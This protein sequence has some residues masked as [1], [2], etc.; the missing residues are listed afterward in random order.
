MQ[1]GE[2]RFV[3]S[4]IIKQKRIGVGYRIG[5]LIVESK[6]DEQRA[7]YTVWL[8]RCVC[9]GEI[10]L[11]TRYLQRGTITDC[12]CIT[13]VKPGQRDLTGQRF[14]KLICIEP[15]EKRL[16]GGNTVW[17]CKC[18]CGKE[19]LAVVKQLTVGYK[20]SCGCLSHPP[21]KDFVGKKFGMLTVIAYEEKRAGMHR[22]RCKCECGNET[23]VGQ[24]LLQAGK[25]QSCGCIKERVI[26][27][28][29]KLVDGTSITALESKKKLA[30]NNKSGY[31]GVYQVKKTGKWCAQIRFKG[32]RYNLGTFDKLEDAVKAR[33]V[34]EEIHDNFIYWYYNEYLPKKES[35]G[36][37]HK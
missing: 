13:K 18:D 23:V 12:G 15:T 6:T 31:T 27:D 16:M 33:R 34:G 2:G 11:D 20:K 26:K 14:G 19:C 3:M 10:K 22:W 5:H 35:N 17:R 36:D 9:G 28:A 32:K 24:T 30:K 29:L 25:T 8:C 7:G 21:L 4:G 1:G 37:S